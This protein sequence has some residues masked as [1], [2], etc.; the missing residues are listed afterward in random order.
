MLLRYF[1]RRQRLSRANLGVIERFKEQMQDAGLWDQWW[2]EVPDDHPLKQL[3][4]PLEEDKIMVEARAIVN[5]ILG[6]KKSG[7]ERTHMNE[8]NDIRK[9]G[10]LPFKKDGGEFYFLLGQAPQGWW[11]DFR[12]GEEPEDGGDLKVTAA[13]SSKK[14]PHLI[15]LCL[16]MMLFVLSTRMLPFI[17]LT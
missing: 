5:K 17:L 6:E 14:S 3:E 16:L 8:R 12:G 13:K 4:E 1:A 7:V 10:I 15:Y 2:S 9:G 11:S